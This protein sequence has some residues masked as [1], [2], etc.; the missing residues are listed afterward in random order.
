MSRCRSYRGAIRRI[1]LH[2]LAPICIVWTEYNT[3]YTS[4]DAANP[5]SAWGQNATVA[6]FFTK[7]KADLKA[8]TQSL[9]VAQ[10]G[11]QGG[12]SLSPRIAFVRACP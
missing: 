3:G 7:A 12:G 9:A 8:T 11:V 1:L 5:V 10:Y 2:P 4:L 6:D